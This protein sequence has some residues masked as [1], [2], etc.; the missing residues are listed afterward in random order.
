MS[1]LRPL[2]NCFLVVLYKTKPEDSPTLQALLRYV[3][4]MEEEV[5]F[6]LYVWDNSP[7]SNQESVKTIELL[8]PSLKIQYVHTPENISLSEI[9]NRVAI[10]IG[11]DSYLTLLDQDTSL[12]HEYFEELG[13]AQDML[14]PLILP[15]VMC[16]GRL[17]SPGLRFFAHGRLQSSVP[18]GKVKSKN[19]LAINSGMSIR[20][21]V[22]HKIRYDERLR[23]YGTDTFFMKQYEIHE[24]TAFVLDT[25]INHSLAEM[26]HRSDEWWRSQKQEKFR[27]FKIIFSDTIVERAF[28]SAYIA[29]D[30]VRGAIVS[31]LGMKT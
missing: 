18:S 29:I 21:H 16:Q 6:W 10:Q 2:K 31:I 5:C 9:Y 17:V 30:K 3:Q 23:F 12:P 13:L 24:S 22:F 28:V 15:K 20:G 8:L 26:E 7:E 1:V 4:N 25:P 19:L 14:E 27:A 11:E